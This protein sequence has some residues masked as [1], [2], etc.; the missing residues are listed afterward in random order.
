MKNIKFT[1]FLSEVEI[2]DNMRKPINNKERNKRI[3]GISKEALF[4]YF[5]ATGLVGYID[6]YITEG[7]YVL[8]G[9]DGAP[10]LNP[11]APKAYII[12]GRTWVNNHAHVLKSKKNNQF[13][14]YY[15]NYFK[16]KDYVSGTTRLKLTQADLKRIPVPDVSLPEQ[17][18][19]VEKLDELFSEL[20]NG[21]E[22]LQKTKAQLKVYRQAVLKDAFQNLTN[23]VQLAEIADTID[24]HPSHRTPPE[25]TGGVPYI[26]IGDINY[27]VREIMFS[28]ARKVSGHVMVDHLNRYIIERGD[29]VM[30]KIGTIGKPFLL[31]LPQKY[32][33]SANVILIK[34]K[35]NKIL[36]SFLFWQF[37]SDY[38][39]KQLLAKS[40][41]TSQPAFGIKKAR[42]LKILI[43]SREKQLHI[44]QEIESHLSICDQIEKTVDEQLQK[45]ESLRQSILKQAFEGRLT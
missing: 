5:G 24:P 1:D 16:Y 26:G 11:F 45:S 33:L 21:I 25:I 31:P 27:A 44:I 39:T 36:P 10:F 43:C 19:I 7:E 35:A 13:L 3:E 15:L 8:L 41:A 38:V 14:C 18:R 22:T 6:D 30:G 9:E 34:P 32:V 42:V 17:N 12:S 40:S 29:F 28:T 23:S 20:D 4:P 37:S 2:H